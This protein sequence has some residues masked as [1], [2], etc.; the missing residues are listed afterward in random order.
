M[1]R[2]LNRTRIPLGRRSRIPIVCGYQ[3]RKAT[4]AAPS[5]N[6]GYVVL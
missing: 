4:A 1:S 5:T 3:S 6:S 2:V